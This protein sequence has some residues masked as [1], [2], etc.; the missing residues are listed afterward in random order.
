MRGALLIAA[1]ASVALPAA[2]QPTPAP[3]PPIIREAPVPAS[4]ESKAM[5][6]WVSAY[7]DLGHYVFVN[8]T[9][10]R[11][12]FFSIVDIDPSKPLIRANRRSE[13]FTPQSTRLGFRYRSTVSLIELDCAHTRSRIL[14]VDAFEGSNLQGAP[15]NVEE[16]DP[17]WRYPR[18]GAIAQEELYQACHARDELIAEAPK[19]A[20]PASLLK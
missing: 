13:F 17:Q 8:S 11:A 7:I 16:Q 14:G 20:P 2:A 6:A 10:S 3:K 9:A 4:P 18:E 5:E 12:Y 1:L 15:R 19:P